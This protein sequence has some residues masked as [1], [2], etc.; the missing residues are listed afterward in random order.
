MTEKARGAVSKP[1]LEKDARKETPVLAEVIE[2][3]GFGLAQ[4]RA[5]LIGGGVFFA[6]GAEILL[7][8]SVTDAVAKSWDLSAGE[9]GLVVTIVFVGILSGNLGAGPISDSFGRRPLIIV[10]FFGIFVFSICSSLT[11]G[12]AGLAIVRFFVGMSF[13]IGQPAWSTLGAEVTP[14]KWRIAMQA[15]SQSFFIGG[16]VFSCLLLLADDPKMKNL[17]WRRLLQLGSIPSVIFGFAALIFLHESPAFLAFRSKTEKAMYV[18]ESMRNDNTHCGG[19]STAVSLEC[20][21]FRMAKKRSELTRSERRMSR[22]ASV[23]MTY[24]QAWAD[25]KKQMGV[26]FG[27]QLLLSTIIVSYCCFVLNFLYYGG[28]YAFPQVLASDKSGK[29][30]GAALELLIGA[31]WELPGYALGILCGVYLYRKRNI[32]VYLF[33]YVDLHRTLQFGLDKYI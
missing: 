1:G 16:E 24:K 5:G 13:G 23:H 25:L 2:K 20:F 33:F 10:S 29:H 32:K 22:R 31:L 27:P 30:S 21:E 14:A 18:L 19:R 28:M 3:I 9:K 17:N 11:M 12:L 6:D 7:I 4:I 8:A 26:V 15:I